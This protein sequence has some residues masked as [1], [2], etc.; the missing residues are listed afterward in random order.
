MVAI[1]VVVFGESLGVVAISR[2][3]W[4]MPLKNKGDSVFFG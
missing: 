3:T 2:Q 1:L 4:A